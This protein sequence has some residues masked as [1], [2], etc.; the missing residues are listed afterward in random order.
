MGRFGVGLQ[1]IRTVENRVD[2]KVI[3]GMAGRLHASKPHFC[4]ADGIHRRMRL[5]Q[6]GIILWRT[7]SSVPIFSP[8]FRVRSKN[9]A[10]AP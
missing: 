2:P 10:V 1:A 4:N 9:S 3:L 6:R 8:R 7:Y 5:R